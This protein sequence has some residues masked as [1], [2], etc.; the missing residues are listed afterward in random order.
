[1]RRRGPPGRL[2]ITASPISEALFKMGTVTDVAPRAAGGPG[3]NV[4]PLRGCQWTVIRHGTVAGFNTST[5]A[6]DPAAFADFTTENSGRR[7]TLTQIIPLPASRGGRMNNKEEAFWW[8]AHKGELSLDKE[9]S[10]FRRVL[11]P[12]RR[13]RRDNGRTG[14]GRIQLIPS[15]HWRMKAR[16]SGITSTPPGNPSV[17]T[18]NRLR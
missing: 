11:R 12:G 14:H 17:V 2:T 4:D 13:P 9:P 16:N 6:D 18:S 8:C 15:R 1:V 5:G 10:F 7:V 3:A